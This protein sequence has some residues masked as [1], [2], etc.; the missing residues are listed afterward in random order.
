MQMSHRHSE[1]ANVSFF[2]GHS[3]WAKR[4]WLEANPQIF[5]QDSSRLP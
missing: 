1:G 3:K 5:H 4:Q 2:D